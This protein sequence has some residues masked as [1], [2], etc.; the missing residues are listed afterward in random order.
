[1]FKF[2]GKKAIK[3]AKS[4]AT[5]FAYKPL[6][7]ASEKAINKCDQLGEKVVENRNKEIK[8]YISES[9][10]GRNRLVLNQYVYRIKETFEVYSNNKEIRYIVKGKLLSLKHQLSIY[11]HTGKN[12]LGEV[13]ESLI[14]LRMPLINMEKKPKNFVLFIGG[15]RIGVIKTKFSLLH[16]KFKIGFNNWTIVGDLFGLKYKIK[17]N[18]KTIMEVDQQISFSKDLYYLDIAEEKDELLC[19]MIALVIDSTHSTKYEDNT[20]LVKKVVR[21]AR[22]RWI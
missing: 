9:D 6:Y 12:K 16:N 18:D 7:D 5:M 21:R 2:L 11:D 14:A 22:S 1:M 17:E 15:K 19:L 10:I 4:V 13:R 3:A 8:K 20:R